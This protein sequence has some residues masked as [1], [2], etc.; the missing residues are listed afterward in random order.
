MGEADAQFERVSGDTS[1]RTQLRQVTVTALV[2]QTLAGARVEQGHALPTQGDHLPALIVATPGEKKSSLGR[3]VPMFTTIV[4]L[5]V[6]GRVASTDRFRVQ[7]DLDT[8]VDQIHAAVMSNYAVLD[9]VQQFAEVETRTKLDGDNRAFI[10]EC[11]VLFHAEI[12]QRYEPP[13]GV[14]LVEITLDL[15]PR[16]AAR[17]ILPPTEK[18]S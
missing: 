13:P 12:F 6:V 11:E 2:G 10:G 3:G 15:P 14:P 7:A 17:I 5:V 1:T 4:Q 18:P 9:I 16:A 8:L